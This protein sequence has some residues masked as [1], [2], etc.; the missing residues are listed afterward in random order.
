MLSHE[1]LLAFIMNKLKDFSK[2]FD[3]F[4]LDLNALRI[5]SKITH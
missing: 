1:V 3:I 4:K 5:H 2:L